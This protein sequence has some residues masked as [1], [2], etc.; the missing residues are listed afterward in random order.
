[1]GGGATAGAARGAGGGG[2]EEEKDEDEEEGRNSSARALPRRDA[3]RAR[4]VHPRLD[5]E[6]RVVEVCH[7]DG[8]DGRAKGLAAP[9]LSRGDALPFLRALRSALRE[10]FC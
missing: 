3:P 10:T 2:K 5:V 8:H 6:R 7:G 9:F 1:L 4:G